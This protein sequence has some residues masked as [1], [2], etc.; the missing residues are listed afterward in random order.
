MISMLQ[1]LYMTAPF[2]NLILMADDGE[3]ECLTKKGTKEIDDNLF[4]QL[5]TMF[6][7]LLL[8]EKQQYSPDEFCFSFKDFEGL[9][10]NTSVQQDAQ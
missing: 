3:P 6:G 7:Y 2:R 10:V 1:Q 8:T 4:H 5:K 9:P